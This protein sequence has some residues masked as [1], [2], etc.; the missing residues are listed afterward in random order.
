MVHIMYELLKELVYKCIQATVCVQVY[1][2]WK[3][4]PQ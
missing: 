3:S 1:Q 2:H 4:A